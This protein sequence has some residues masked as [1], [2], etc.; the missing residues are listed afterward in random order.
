MDCNQK[1]YWTEIRKK[2]QDQKSD[3][4][5]QRKNWEKALDVFD[6]E[7]NQGKSNRR[8]FLKLCGFSLALGGVLSSCENPV[9]KAIPYLIPPEEIIP[10]KANYYASSYAK[11]GEYCSILVKTREGRPIKIEGNELSTITRGGTSSRV[12]AS[13]LDLYDTSRY[14]NAL[15]NGKEISWEKLDAEVISHLK[16]MKKDKE[17]IALITPSI[18]SPST[19]QLLKSFLRKYNNIEWVQYDSQSASAMLRANKICFGKEGISDYRF[20]NADLIVSFDSDFLSTH[21][22]PVENIRLYAQNR[23]LNYGKKKMSRH[24][25]FE[26]RLSLTGSNA[27]ER[28]LIKPSELPK[29]LGYL[30]NE[31]RREKNKKTYILGIAPAH[32]KKLAKELWQIREKSLVLAGANDLDVQLLVNL[33]NHELGNYSRT[34]DK[35]RTLQV[36]QAKDSEF[37]SLLAD[38]K[39]KQIKGVI[40]Y[41]INP[42]YDYYKGE[43]FGKYLEKLRFSLAI[44]DTPNETSLLA[45][46]VA[47]DHHYLESWNDL[48]ARTKSY[49]LTQPVIR[50]LFNTRQFQNS[51]LKWM[52]QDLDFLAYMKNYW[53]R[54]IFPSQNQYKDFIAFWKTS[55]Q[56]GVYE[57]PLIASLHLTF[58]MKNPDQLMR[59]VLRRSRYDGVELQVYPSNVLLD[60]K[61]ANNPWLQELPDPLSKICWDNYLNISA[62]QAKELDVETGDV[63]EIN[64]QIKLPVYIAPGQ[65]Y[66]TVSVALGY[67]RKECGKVGKDIG[68]NVSTF[69]RLHHKNRI[70]YTGN[71]HLYKTGEKYP[72]AMTQTHPS[73]EGRPIVKEANLDEWQKD[74]K[75]GNHSHHHYENAGI[76]KKPKFPNHHWGMLVDLNSCVGCGAC[77]IACQAENNIPVVGKK[78]VGR[79]HEMAWIR[80]DRY[81]SGEEENPEVVFQPVMCQHCDNAP[82]ENVCPVAATNHNSEGLNQMAYN[83]CIG[84]R[85]CGNN[86]PYKVRRFN[87]YDYTKADSIPHNLHDPA[88]MT[89]D[90]KRMVLNPD[91]TIRAK[92]VIEKCSMCVQRIQ[93][94]KLNA[95]LENRKLRDGEIRT[96]CQQACP[97]GAIVFGDLNDKEGILSKM[98]EQ[99]RNYHLLEEIHTL[100]SVSYL[101][102]IRN[103]KSNQS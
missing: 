103:Q 100:P 37:E 9:Q 5:L 63:I 60:G 101:T 95:K 50:P 23:K 71:I 47:A 49:S 24:I 76:Y 1:K 45:K 12:Q 27:D 8:D 57:P 53:K 35:D 44:N 84:T 66:N 85:Y 36:K 21:L 79:G 28:H 29:L 92:G 88:D 62:K 30:Y 39:T 32:I 41:D 54:K 25:Q 6:D 38:L 3:K 82:C 77:S 33:I 87:W 74:A 58:R 80:I 97:A 16:Q 19:R 89:V 52:G 65:A 78:E 70:D 75:A 64:K 72:L 55:L 15:K 7:L 68:Q 13:V 11:G 96:A 73:M 91:V 83:R 90:L 2:E 18:Y 10:G 93:E 86:C 51:L 59:R 22:L 20:D 56:K 81:F 4:D 69:I 14:R 48:E 34:I 102:K 31:I 42:V 40:C 46:Y 98:N 94:G 61:M 43:E 17:K 26:S 67:G 99:K